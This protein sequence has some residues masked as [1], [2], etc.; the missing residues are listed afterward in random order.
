MVLPDKGNANFYFQ[1]F[2]RKTR[3]LVQACYTQTS[4]FYSVITFYSVL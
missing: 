4:S 1:T 3:W 2:S